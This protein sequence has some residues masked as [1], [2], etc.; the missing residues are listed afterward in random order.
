MRASLPSC[1]RACRSCGARIH[2]LV[3]KRDGACR[4]CR[5]TRCLSPDFHARF[6][7]FSPAFHPCFIRF[8]QCSFKG[9]FEM[10]A[11]RA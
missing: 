11:C 3:K 7:R 9:F 4:A 6:I 10:R 1:E 8:A 2:S 5:C